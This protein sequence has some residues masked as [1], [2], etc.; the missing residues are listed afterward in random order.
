MGL[1]KASDTDKD[2]LAYLTE[3]L[4]RYGRYL[5][6]FSSYVCLLPAN[7]QGI[8][9][10]E[11]VPPWLSEFAI[12]INTQMKYCMAEKCNLSECHRFF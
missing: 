6:I 8:W 4:F 12:N 3:F 11:F 7:L 5:L 10:G 2:R 1:L 9:N